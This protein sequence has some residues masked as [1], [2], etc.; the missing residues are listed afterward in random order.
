M[1]LFDQIAGAALG[2][3][4]QQVAAVTPGSDPGANPA[5]TPAAALAAGAG[6]AIQAIMQLVQQQGGLQGLLDKLRN[7]GLAEIVQSWVGTGANQPVSPAQL[8]TALGEQ[9]VG[10]LAG[11]A[12]MAPQELLG[13]LSQ[14]LPALVNQL[15]PGGELPHDMAGLLQAGLN[16][17]HR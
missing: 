6:P 9:Q 2:A 17:L 16:L 4:Q 10:Q 12:G 14:H 1:G 8:N 5:A 13:L 3:L 15:S 7:G 11:A